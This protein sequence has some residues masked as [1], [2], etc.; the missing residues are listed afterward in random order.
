MGIINTRM[1]DIMKRIPPFKRTIF[2]VS[3]SL[4]LT[5]HESRELARK[6]EHSGSVVH[7]ECLTRDRG[8]VGSSLTRF[9]AVCP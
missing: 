6:R 2:E 8:A 1:V 9:T 7:V 4:L 3:G 5:G